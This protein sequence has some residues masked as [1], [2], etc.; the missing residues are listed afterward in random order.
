VDAYVL[1]A[2]TLIEEF[3]ADHYRNRPW[4]PG[5]SP[6]SAIGQFMAERD[7]FV[8]DSDWSRRAL[9]TEFRDGVLRR[10]S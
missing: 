2:D 1:V 6:A 8:I 4:G 3:P 7:D 9:V 5:N 10:V